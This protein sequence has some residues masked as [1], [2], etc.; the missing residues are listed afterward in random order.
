[1]ETG[2]EGLE[3]TAP[4]TVRVMHNVPKGS[5]ESLLRDSLLLL[6][7]YHVYVHVCRFHV[8]LPQNRLNPKGVPAPRGVLLIKVRWS[9][10]FPK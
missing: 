4:Q 1:M 5:K 8:V 10:K 7:A 2:T 9:P 6:H 3:H